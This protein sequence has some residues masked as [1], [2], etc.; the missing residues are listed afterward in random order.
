M[1]EILTELDI[2]SYATSAFAVLLSLYNWYKMNRPATIQPSR[3]VNYG[4]IASSYENSFLFCFPLIFENTGSKKG[5]ITE[6]KLAYK[7]GETKKYIDADARVR[8]HELK[9][10]TAPRMD[11]EKFTDE[12]YAILL[13]TYPIVVEGG[14]TIDTT[15]ISTVGIDE[16]IVPIAEEAKLIIEVYFGK[17]KKQTK[18]IP[19][20]LSKES[21][22]SDDVLLWLKP[23]DKDV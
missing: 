13:P 17:N 8:L 5:V 18:E 2:M 4:F 10:A 21:A 22:D 7:V 12:G 3:M 9:G 14:Q 20:Y 23:I 6:I 19:F 11:F 1:S 16:D 15:I